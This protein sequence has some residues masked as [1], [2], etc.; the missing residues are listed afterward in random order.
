ML[1]ELIT[2]KQVF[3]IISIG[4]L[5]TSRYLHLR[6]INVVVYNDSY[7]LAV[8]KIN[9]EGGFTLICFQRLS[10]RYVT[11]QLCHW[12]DN[13]SIRGTSTPILSY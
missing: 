12:R 10:G 3:R 6:P 4:Q 2:I 9:L 5:N 7:H 13:W 8:G 1:I 11:T